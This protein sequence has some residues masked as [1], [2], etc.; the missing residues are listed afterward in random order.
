LRLLHVTSCY[1]GSPFASDVSDV[2]QSVS[3]LAPSNTS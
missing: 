3:M 2:N 1:W